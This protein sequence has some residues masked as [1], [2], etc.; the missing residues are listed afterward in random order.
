VRKVNLLTTKTENFDQPTLDCYLEIVHKPLK[1]KGEDAFA[2]NFE[3]DAVHYQAVFD[4]C[5]GSGSWQ[6]AEYKNATGAFIAAQSMAKAFVEWSKAV[7]TA[8][9]EDATRIEK[10]F[11]AMAH[12]VLSE[13]KRSCA[14]MKVSGSL[15]KSFPCT[16]SVAI[17]VPY[18]DYLALSILNIGDSRVYFMAPQTGL[19]QLTI[20]DSQGD[21]DPLESLRDS[22]PMSD[23]LNADNPFQIKSRQL[24]LTYP[25]AVIT[26]TDGVFGYFRSPMDFEFIL[27]NAIMLS[28]SFAQCEELLKEAV[29]K[30]TGDDSTCIIAFYGWNSFENLKRKMSKRYKHILSLIEVLDTAM[31]N[32][33]FDEVLEATWKEYKKQ[34]LIDEMQG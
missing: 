2:Y 15:V 17:T 6:Y 9:L 32:G 5:G 19:V 34:T 13:L 26:A 3:S 21:P 28:N 10:S 27:L 29:L 24:S 18:K 4:G 11:H 1:E 14:P 8:D 33:N 16:A 12:R 25:C 31:E 20:D 30:V 23:M 22:A 7:S